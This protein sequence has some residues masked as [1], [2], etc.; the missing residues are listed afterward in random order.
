MSETFDFGIIGGGV[1]GLS[2]AWELS[3]RGSVLVLDRQS[4]GQEASWAGAGILPPAS[5]KNAIHPRE[6]LLALSFQLHEQWAAD[7]KRES[8]IDNGYRKCGA[9][10]VAR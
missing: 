2:L 6:K 3:T 8:G 10:H 1:I 7:L 5:T 9:I 4:V